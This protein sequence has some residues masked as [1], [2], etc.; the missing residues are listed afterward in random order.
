MSDTTRPAPP[1]GT[2]RSTGSPLPG[3]LGQGTLGRA[4]ALVYWYV[5]VTAL[6]ALAALPTLSLIHI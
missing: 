3:A 1:S 5:V 6:L 4:T 2:G